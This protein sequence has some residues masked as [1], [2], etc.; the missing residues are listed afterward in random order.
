M[1]VSQAA[2]G[3]YVK[4]CMPRRALDGKERLLFAARFFRIAA[5]RGKKRALVAASAVSGLASGDPDRNRDRRIKI[6]PH[7]SNPPRKRLA[8]HQYFF[9]HLLAR[10]PGSEPS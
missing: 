3:V 10:T 2:L 9:P 5:R 4:L 7:I 8:R 1:S 6:L